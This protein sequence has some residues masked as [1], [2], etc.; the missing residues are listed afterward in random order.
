[1]DVRILGAHQSDTCNFR[2][3]SLL[4]D[5]TLAIDAGGLSGG[6]SLDEQLAVRQVLLTHQHWDHLKDLPG[7]GYNL[8]SAAGVAGQAPLGV[9]LYGSDAVR[10]V[11]GEFL[12]IP[13][14]WLSFFERPSADHP[15]FR[16]HLVTAATPFTVGAYRVRAIPTTHSVPVLGYE[17]TDVQGRRLYYTGDNGPGAGRFW[18]AAMPHLLITECTYSNAMDGADEGRVHGHLT[19]RQLEA[20]LMIFRSVRGYLPTVALVHLSPFYEA[21]IR[22]E[23]AEVASRLGSSIIVGAEGMQ[24]TV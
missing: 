24:L 7:F 12:G 5:G 13:D 2:F 17:V 18:T 15:V 20:E 4:V 6:L 1:M 23:V 8:L 10:R 16:Y 19:P 21:Q 9:D 22:V 14:F 11:L 3:A